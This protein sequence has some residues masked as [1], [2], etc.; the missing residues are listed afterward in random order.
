MILP[1][2]RS[3][4]I[5]VTLPEKSLIKIKLLTTI[6]KTPNHLPYQFSDSELPLNNDKD[7]NLTEDGITIF[8]AGKYTSAFIDK[9]VALVILLDNY[10]KSARDISAGL[11]T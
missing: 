2:Y 5:L 8:Q 6:S 1:P 3:K 7:N 10:S 11:N 4:T 9:V